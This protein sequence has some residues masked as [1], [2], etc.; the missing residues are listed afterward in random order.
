MNGDEVEVPPKYR[1]PHPQCQAVVECWQDGNVWRFSGHRRTHVGEWCR[2][3]SYQV[4]Q[5]VEPMR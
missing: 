3:F 5:G 2:E 1:C 4:A